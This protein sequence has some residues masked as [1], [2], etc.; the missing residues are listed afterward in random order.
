MFSPAPLLQFR[1]S[2]SIMFSVICEWIKRVLKSYCDDS[3]RCSSTIWSMWWDCVHSFIVLVLGCLSS[4]EML[5]SCIV[6]LCGS[7]ITEQDLYSNIYVAWNFFVAIKFELNRPTWLI[8]LCRCS[9]LSLFITYIFYAYEY[10]P[11][12]VHANRWILSWVLET[13]AAFTSV[14]AIPV[15]P[16]S[17]Q[18]ESWTGSWSWLKSAKFKILTFFSPLHFWVALGQ[19]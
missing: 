10:L 11:T 8:C 6:F 5:K 1:F 9:F 13:A 15:S 18:V 12:Y 3:S 16:T 14:S 17:L 2:R 7:F 19:F 4:F